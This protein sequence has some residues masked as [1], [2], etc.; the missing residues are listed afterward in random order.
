[1]DDRLGLGRR[2]E[3]DHDW[4]S[5]DDRVNLGGPE[6]DDDLICESGRQKRVM[7]AKPLSRCRCCQGCWK[8]HSA[9]AF[10]LIATSVWG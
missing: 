9:T 8:M 5:M 6:L 3:F 10:R 1:M 4:I 2:P 7:A